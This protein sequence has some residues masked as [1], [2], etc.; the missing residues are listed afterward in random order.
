MRTGASISPRTGRD[1]LDCS[2]M[3]LRRNVFTGTNPEGFLCVS[4]RRTG[5]VQQLRAV[6]VP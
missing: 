5:V 2:G 4:D 1:K 6:S 3:F